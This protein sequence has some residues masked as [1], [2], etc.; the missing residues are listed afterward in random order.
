MSNP[1]YINVNKVKNIITKTVIYSIEIQDSYNSGSIRIE[2]EGVPETDLEALQY[3]INDG[4]VQ[5]KQVFD[6]VNSILEYE[7]G[8]TINATFYDWDEIKHLFNEEKQCN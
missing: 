7:S 3:L 2:D 8:V 5:S 4:S 6:V 1:I